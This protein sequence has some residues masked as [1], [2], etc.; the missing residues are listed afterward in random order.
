MSTSIPPFSQSRQQLLACPYSYV[1]QVIRGNKVPSG[2]A[3]R[4]GT[5]IHDFLNLYVKHLSG[6]KLRRDYAF[7][8][9][10]LKGMEPS[11]RIILED[12]REMEIDPDTI[13]STEHRISLTEDFAPDP[14]RAAPA[15]EGTLDLILVTDERRAMIIDYKSQFAA[16]D[17]EDTFQGR[18]YPMLLFCANPM[19]EEIEFTLRFLRWGKERSIKF[20]RDDV[21]RLQAE[22]RQW[23]EMQVKL[24][25]LIDPRF[26][27]SEASPGNHCVYCPLLWDGCPIEKNPFSKEPKELVRRALY[28]KMALKAHMDVLKPHCDKD[29]AVQITDSIGNKY[30]AGWEV[31][32]RKSYNLDVLPTLL[33]WDN[34][35]KS[36]PVIP[37]LTVSGLTQLVKAKKRADLADTVANFAEVKAQSRFRIGKIGE[38]DD[39]D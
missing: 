27:E 29:G 8:E 19:F 14:N 2:E 9:H 23:R 12:L 10:L 38:R 21:E 39:E 18:F 4:R 36:D 20:C 16:V 37:K 31:Q 28:H 5:A 7:F 35:H 24:H 32:E 3:A 26:V 13:Y 6:H 30:E 1:E 15:Y 33:E 25:G 11:A 22:A 17:P 34:D